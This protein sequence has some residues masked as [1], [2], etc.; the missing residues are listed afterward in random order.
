MKTL[1]HLLGLL[2]EAFGCLFLLGAIGNAIEP[3]SELPFWLLEGVLI[4]LGALLSAGGYALL[5]S[6]LSQPT[7]PCPKCGGDK[8]QQAGVLVRSHNAWFAHFGGWLFAA[9]WGASRERQVRCNQC[10]ALYFTQ[11]RGSRI[12]GIGLWVFILM[13]AIAILVELLMDGSGNPDPFRNDH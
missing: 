13:I 9:L 2:L 12:A 8:Y 10:E 1:K 4:F 3:D 6:K 7:N 11:T 5:R